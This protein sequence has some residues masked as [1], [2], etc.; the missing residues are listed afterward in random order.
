MKNIVYVGGGVSTIFSVIKL[1]DNGYPGDKITIL[2]KGNPMKDRQPN[3][4]MNGFGGAGSFS[5]YKCVYSLTQG[6]LLSKYTGDEKAWSLINEFKEITKRFHPKPQE[7]KTVTIKDEPIFIKESSFELKQSEV[8]HLGTDYG[9]AVMKNIEQYFRE[10]NVRMIFNATVDDIDFDNKMISYN[11]NSITNYDKLIIATGKSG[12]DLVK[13]L[14]DKYQLKTTPKAAQIG[15]R[16]ESDYRYFERLA[17]DFYDF[18]LYRKIDDNISLRS[19][20]VNNERAHVAEENTYGMKSYNGHAYKTGEKNNLINF[21]IIM[22]IKSI[23]NPLEFTLDLVKR[24]NEGGKGKYFTL[25]NRKPN[26]DVE[27]ITIQNFLILYNE[28]ANHILGFIRDM[29]RIFNFDDD[30]VCYVPEIKYLT[31]EIAV[32]NEDLSL[33]DYKDIH[34]IGDALSARGIVISASQGLYLSESIIK[35]VK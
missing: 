26:L 13:Q 34:I 10:K 32:N 15:V 4:I 24:C 22:E 1:L 31:N 6:G 20:C 16:F 11:G 30:Y 21:G 18:K 14:I 29:D 19:F 25:S 17:K 28:Y 9:Q 23:D 8:E 12:M 3:E 27:Q 33:I 2:E 35:E 7:I 5:D